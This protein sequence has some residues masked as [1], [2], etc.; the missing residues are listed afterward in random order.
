MSSDLRLHPVSCGIYK[1]TSPSGKIYIG[2]SANLQLRFYY[3]TMMKCKSQTKLYHSFKKYGFKS[4]IFEVIHEC[5]P[6][7]LNT[8]E[9]YYIDLFQ[10]FN[11]RHGLNL[12]DGG[13]NNGRHSDVTRAKISSSNIGRKRSAQSIENMRRAKIGTKL[14]AEQKI[15]IGIAHT[16]I[17]NGFYGKKHSSA[18][19]E[20]W[21]KKRKGISHNRGRL[22]LNIENGI[23]YDSIRSAAKSIDIKEATF[24]WRVRNSKSKNNFIYV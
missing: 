5:D 8:L 16:G 20:N 9:K 2:Q 6:E 14:T 22:V 15:K 13:G 19:R 1:I 17:K 23:Y 24:R 3:Y 21:S 10:T 11:S 18:T 7:D 4:H 12:R